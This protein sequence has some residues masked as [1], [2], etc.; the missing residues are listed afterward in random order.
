MEIRFD[1]VTVDMEV[2]KRVILNERFAYEVK[3]NRTTSG[4]V[5]TLRVD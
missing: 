1:E 4:T 5:G 2:A 3:S